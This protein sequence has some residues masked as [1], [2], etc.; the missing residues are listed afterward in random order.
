[1]TGWIVTLYDRPPVRFE[2]VT[3]FRNHNVFQKG[4]ISQNLLNPL[5]YVIEINDHWHL[6]KCHIA[7]PKH[8]TH[9]LDFRA[10]Q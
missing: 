8:I 9:S 6:S 2:C 7:F 1:M 4:R 3:Y 5:I 10:I